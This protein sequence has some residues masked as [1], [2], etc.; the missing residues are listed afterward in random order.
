MYRYESLLILKLKTLG[1]GSRFGSH[2]RIRAGV[3]IRVISGISYL[4]E[5]LRVRG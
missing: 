1:T 2:I 5:G 4:D 3:A